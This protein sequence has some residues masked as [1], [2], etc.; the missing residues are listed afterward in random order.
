MNKK[1]DISNCKIEKKEI[2]VNG[3][4]LPLKIGDRFKLSTKDKTEKVVMGITVFEDGRAQY[5]LE[6]HDP[7][8]GQFNTET[9]TMTE[10]KLLKETI[11]NK[12]LNKIGFK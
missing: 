9:V 3:E 7:D 12:S 2:S 10:I 4:A 8:S 1:I 5:I 6:W 11:D